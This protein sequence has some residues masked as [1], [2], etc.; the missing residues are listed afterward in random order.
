MKLLTKLKLRLEVV[1][2]AVNLDWREVA[3]EL[4]TDLFEERKRRFAFEQENYD[5]KQELAAYKY[6][7]NFDIKARLQG[8]V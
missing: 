2:K 8:E 5:L 3:V 4:M 1:L 7:E 6:K